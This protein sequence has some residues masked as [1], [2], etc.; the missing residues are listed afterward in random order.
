MGKKVDLYKCETK[1]E[2]INKIDEIDKLI[3]EILADITIRDRSLET[4]KKFIKSLKK[5]IKNDR[6][7]IGFFVEEQRKFRE[8]LNDQY[9]S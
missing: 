3:E 7:A 5:R 2:Y 9:P 8:H 4:S 6:A 1:A